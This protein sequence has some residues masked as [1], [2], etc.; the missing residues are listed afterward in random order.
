MQFPDG[1][2][3]HNKMNYSSNSLSTIANADFS[4]L[5]EDF[6]TDPR[7]FVNRWESLDQSPTLAEATE[8]M[9]QIFEFKTRLTSIH[10]PTHTLVALAYS[11][12]D[13]RRA[14]CH[15]G[16]FASEFVVQGLQ[17]DM[18]KSLFGKYVETLQR[19]KES[20]IRFV[21]QNKN[22]ANGLSAKQSLM[23]SFLQAERGMTRIQLLKEHSFFN[24]RIYETI[25]SHLK[26][27]KE[28]KDTVFSTLEKYMNVKL[29][30]LMDDAKYP[31]EQELSFIFAN[32]R[33]FADTIRT[34]ID[35][36][37]PQDRRYISRED[38]S[39]IER[40]T[41]EV[42]MQTPVSE[43]VNTMQRSCS[44]LPTPPANPAPTV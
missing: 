23:A 27:P 17:Q 12:W 29:Q 39:E 7:N 6:I 5:P 22:N 26:L 15:Q 13:D 28:D 41:F 21:L 18:S 30:D 44:A 34:K 14:F 9:C 25:A 10:E 32:V 31:D 37:H 1:F 19:S 35:E 38:L 11:Q 3:I 36:T 33:A 24:T 42:M 16:S 8:D 4:N 20:F 40:D 2:I 43:I